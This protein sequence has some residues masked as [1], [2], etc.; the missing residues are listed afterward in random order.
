[1]KFVY[2]KT[3]KDANMKILVAETNRASAGLSGILDNSHGQK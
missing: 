3:K 2:K 1:M